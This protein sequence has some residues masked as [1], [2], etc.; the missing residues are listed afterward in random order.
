MIDNYKDLTIKK[1]LEI[2]KILQEDGGELNIQ[3]RIV[4]VLNDMDV[5]DVLNL[6]L[7]RYHELV[8]RS[9]FLMNKPEVSAKAPDRLVLGGQEF[10][11]TKNTRKLTTAQYIDYQTITSMQNAD[12][13]LPNVLAC[14]II[15]KG[16]TYGD[17][18]EVDDVANLISEHMSIVDA[19][20]ICFFFRK[21]YL[22][23]I[24]YTLRYLELQMRMMKRKE[25]NQEA[26][27]KLEEAIA[28]MKELQNALLKSGDGWQWSKR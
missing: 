8:V 17:G 16:K 27:M 5:D 24:S 7:D 19:L 11:I 15:P 26:R 25:K 18:Y 23:S 28:K 6:K 20:N 14:F 22:N 12:D 9:G 1:Y 13:M 2:R 10:I 21:R 4:A 3:T